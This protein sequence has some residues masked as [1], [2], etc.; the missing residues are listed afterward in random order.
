MAS[1]D[2]NK[3]DIDNLIFRFESL[4]NLYWQK[5]MIFVV[6]VSLNFKTMAFPLMKSVQ[7]DANTTVIIRAVYSN[8]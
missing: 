6:N 4:T 8:N 5:A 1:V 2:L 7:Y 3:G